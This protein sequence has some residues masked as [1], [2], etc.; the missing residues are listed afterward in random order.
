VRQL[1][2]VKHGARAE[3][4]SALMK[5]VAE[6]LSVHDIVL[7]AAYAGSLKP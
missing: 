3:L 1:Y 6:R 5:P 4:G 2:D 7:L